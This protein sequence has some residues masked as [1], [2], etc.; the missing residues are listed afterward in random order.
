MKTKIMTHDHRKIHSDIYRMKPGPVSVRKIPAMRY[1]AQEM[2]TA[3]RMDWA[4]RPEPIDEAWLVW[5]VVNQLK[6]MTKNNLDYKFT[7]MP[8]EILWHEKKGENSL[9]TQMM[10]V[11]DCITHEMFDEAQLHVA[12]SLKRNLPKMNLLHAEPVMCVQKLHVGHYRETTQTLNE[13][14]NYAEQSGHKLNK[15]H[16]E[17]YLTPAMMCHKPETWRTVVSVEIHN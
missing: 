9:V 13:V 2:N 5:K 16:R 14:L 8:H 6:K 1:I 3:Y 15:S 17:I 12:K 7:L 11:P 4:G 10:Q